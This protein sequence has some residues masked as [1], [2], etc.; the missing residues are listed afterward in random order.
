MFIY[1]VRASNET[2]F[3]KI[4]QW[5]PSAKMKSQEKKRGTEA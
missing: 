2:V 3:L 1:V 5:N 4:K